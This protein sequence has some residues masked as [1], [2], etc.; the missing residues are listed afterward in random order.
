ML[1]GTLNRIADWSVRNSRIVSYA[2]LAMTFV[3]GAVY[4]RFITIP[5]IPYITEDMLFWGSIGWNAIWWGYIHGEL[6]KRRETLEQPKT[7]NRGG[8][9][10]KKAS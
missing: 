2:S 4:A 5:D 6:Q 1:D 3:T 8:P 7:L 9:E 10:D